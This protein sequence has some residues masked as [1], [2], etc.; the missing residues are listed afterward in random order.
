MAPTRRHVNAIRCHSGNHSSS[1]QESR[2]RW[3]IPPTRARRV[4][5]PSR[6]LRRSVASPLVLAAFLAAAGTGHF[7]A[8]SIYERIVPRVLGHS[9][10]LV[11]VSGMAEILA[12]AL[13]ALPRTRRLGAW[14]TIAL[15][16]AVF[17]ANVQMALDGGIKDAGFPAN[18]AV[19]S[20]LRLPFQVPLIAWAHRFTRS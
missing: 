14:F 6:R 15:L 11:Q 10:L 13:L 12:G 2:Y 9:R 5:V 8:S 18:S 4:P 17:P 20:W 3:G 1:S 16:V 7:V 19:L